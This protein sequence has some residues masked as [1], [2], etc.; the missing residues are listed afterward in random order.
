MQKTLQQQYSAAAAHQG[1]L[2][3]CQE[4][5]KQKNVFLLNMS[6]QK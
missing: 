5:M 4:N 3:S 2:F 1:I 6:G